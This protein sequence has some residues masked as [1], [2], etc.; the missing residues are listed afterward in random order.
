MS[1][2]KLRSLTLFAGLGLG[3]ALAACG[4]LEDDAPEQGVVLVEYGTQVDGL[5]GM[6]V[7]TTCSCEGQ[8]APPCPS[9]TTSLGAYCSPEVGGCSLQ[10]ICQS[11]PPPPPPGGGGGEPECGPGTGRICN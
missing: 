8:V 10:S 3:A 9:P 7:G 5:W 11:P 1:T 6:Q 2:I 4:G